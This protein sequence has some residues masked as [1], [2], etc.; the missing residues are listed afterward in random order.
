VRVVIDTNVLISATFWPGKPK[1]L[2]NQVR[3]GKIDFLTSEILIAELKEVL[4]R[5]DKPFKLSEEEAQHALA[6]IM[7]IAE[8]VEPHSVI[9]RCQD[10]T[11]NRVLECAVDGQA[12]WI[13]TGD[14]DLLDL[15]SFA[16][17]KIVTVAEFLCATA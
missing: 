2:L 13:I 14:R 16:G 7:D 6:A 3:R 12:D 5:D 4:T 17:I 15:K 9:T 10:E 1:Q 8:I 11:D